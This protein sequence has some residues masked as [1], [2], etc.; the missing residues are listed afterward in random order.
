MIVLPSLV[1]S[2]YKTLQDHL[3]L[4]PKEKN[5]GKKPVL[6][7]APEGMEP[8][9]FKTPLDH[10]QDTIKERYELNYVDDDW[11]NYWTLGKYNNLLSNRLLR[12]DEK[13]LFDQVWVGCYMIKKGKNELLGYINGKP[14]FEDLK[15]IPEADQATWLNAFGVKRPVFETYDVNDKICPLHS[16]S[17]ASYFYKIRTDSDVNLNGMEAFWNA[18]LHGSRRKNP[19]P[20]GVTLY[21]FMT[22]WREGD[23]MIMPYACCT[24]KNWKKMGSK[25]EKELRKMIK[26]IKI[27]DLRYMLDVSNLGQRLSNWIVR[28]NILQEKEVK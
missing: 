9:F 21:T 11:M 15:K 13:S 27:K 19:H 16:K 14:W 3:I 8:K 2:I 24:E 26:S 6:G 22:V 23:L 28:K 10:P 4:S 17:E 12:F 20:K 25:L 1:Y 5:I 7:Y 18:I